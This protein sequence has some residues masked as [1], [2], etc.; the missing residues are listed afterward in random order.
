[1]A[2]KSGSARATDEKPQRMALLND[3]KVRGR[4]IQVVLLIIIVWLIYNYVGIHNMH[5]INLAKA[6]I[7]SGFAFLDSTAGFGVS[8]FAPDREL[9]R[10]PRLMRD[11]Y[12]VG[13]H[14]TLVVGSDRGVICHHAWFHHRRG[15]AFLQSR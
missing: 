8:H 12:M 10:K 4:I 13:F 11:V 15:P 7:A 9:Q 3:P 14:N 1:M 2:V 5:A 6:G